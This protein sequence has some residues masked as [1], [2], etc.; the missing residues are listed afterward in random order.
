MKTKTFT[1]LLAM[2][3]LLSAATA[4]NIHYGENFELNSTLN[5]NQSHEYY[6]SDF[7]DLNTGFLSNPQNDNHTLLEINPY[8]NTPISFGTDQYMPQDHDIGGRLG[9]YPMDFHVN[10]YGAATISIPLE[11]PEWI[12]G[13]TPHLSLEYN[14]QAGNGILGLGWSLGGMSKIS[15]V[16]YTYE[17][18]DECHSVQF[19]NEDQLSLDGIILKKGTFNGTTC[20]YPEIYDYS[21]VR[22][23]TGGFKVLRR[24]GTI[25]TYTAKYYLQ[26]AITKPIE[27]HLSNV[28][29]PYGNYIEY[30]YENDRAD[31]AFYP[32]K[33]KYTGRTGHTPA[34]EIRLVYDANDAR[35][36][37]PQKWFSQ[38]S[39]MSCNAGFSRVTRKLSNIECWF[40]EKRIIRYNLTYTT[41]DWNIR[42]LAY[43]EKQFHDY[44]GGTRSYNQVIPLKFVWSKTC[45]NLQYEQAGSMINLNTS[46]N[47]D[48]EWHQQTAFAARFKQDNL[49]NNQ[50]YEHDIVHLMRK[51]TGPKFYHLN[52]FRSNNEIGENGQSYNFNL[53]DCNTINNN[54]FNDG[55]SIN[56][57]MSADTDGDGLDEIVC[58]YSHSNT[59]SISLL[60]P[61]E[62]N[63]FQETVV[64]PSLPSGNFNMSSFQIGDFNGD[65]LSDLFCIY[66]NSIYVRISTVNG[67]FSQPASKELS[68]NDEI[69]I[70]VADFNGDQK[71]QILVLFKNGNNREAKLFQMT[72]QNN[73]YSIPAPRA[74]P[75]EISEKYYLNSF[76]RLCCG[77]FNGDGK[78]DVL[79]ICTGEWRFY[80][81]QGNGMFAPV[82]LLTDNVIVTDNFAT[83]SDTSSMAFAV[84]SDFDHDGCD[85]VSITLQQDFDRLTGYQ[86]YS[87]FRGAFRRDFLIRPQ[88]QGVIVRRIRNLRTW[89]ENGIIQEEDRCI[90]SVV[91]NQETFTSKKVFLPVLGNHKGI[92]PNEILYCRVVNAQSR[93]NIGAFLHN[94]GNFYPDSLTRSVNRI[95]TSLGATIDIRYRPVSY[96]YYLETVSDKSGRSLSEVLPFY[97]FMNVVEEIKKENE[98]DGS[99]MMEGKKYRSSRYYYMRPQI[100]T[101]G[102]GF[103]GFECIWSKTQGQVPAQ[104]IVSVKEYSLDQTYHV[105]VPQKFTLRPPGSTNNYYQR[106]IYT[107]SFSDPD[108]FA[109]SLGQIPN[110]VFAPYLSVATTTR[111]DG[112]PLKY[113]KTVTVRDTYGNVSSFERWYRDN[114]TT[115]YPYY[116]KTETYYD[117]TVTSSRWILGIP[118]SGTTTQRLTDIPPNQV[119]HHTSYQ[120]D[121]THGRHLNKITEPNSDKQ[122]TETYG[123]DGFGNLTSVTEDIGDGH[124]RTDTYVYS[125]DSRFMT[126]HTNAKGHTTQYYYH[127]ATGLLDSVT[128]PN[129][130]TTKY[131]YDYLCNL[132]KTEL[133]SGILEEQVMRWVGHPL[134]NTYHPDTP[135]FGAPIYFVWS[136]RS[137]ER[138]RYTFYDQ[139]RRM[140]REVDSTMDGKKIYVDYRYHD[141]TGL[142]DSVSAPYYPEEHETA[143]F[144]T[145]QYDYLG[146][147][148]W[149][150]RPDGAFTS[151]SYAGQQE[152][153]QGFDGQRRTLTYNPAGLV[154]KVSDHGISN[155]SPVE[156]DYVRYGDGKVKTS[157]VGNESATTITYIYDVNGNP[158]TV[159]DPSLGQLTYDYNG[160]GELVYS[161][162]PRDTVTYTYDALGRMVTRN[163]LDGYSHWQ[164]DA[165]FKGALSQTHYNPVSGP[166]VSEYFTYDR[167]GNPTRHRQQVGANEEWTFVYGYDAYGQR[168]AVTYPSGKKFRWHYDRNGYMDRVTDAASNTMVWQATATDRWGNT[169]EFTEGNIGVAY[170]YDPVSGLL[171]GISARKNGQTLFGQACSWTTVGN[172][173]WR[174]DTTLNLRETFDH[175]RFNRLETAYTKNLVGTTTYSSNSFGFDN[176]G[177][178]TQKDGV[179]SY[180][181]DDAGPYVLTELSPLAGTESLYEDQ[182]ATYTPFDKL[183]SVIQDV[184]T[185]SVNYGI[186]RQRVTQSFTD[187]R[188]TKTKRYFTSL[189][190]TVTENG[191]TK[192]LHYLTSA[193]G[194][195]AIFV[196]TSSGGGTMYYTLKDHQGSLAAVVYGNTM[197]RLSYDAWGNLR[198]PNTWANYTVDDTFDKPMFDRGFTG[199]EHLTDFGLINMNGR[200]YDPIL[201][202][203]LSPDVVIQDEQN[204]QAYNR[205]SYCFNNP[206]RYTDPSGYVVTI[207]PEFE[208]YYMPQY[209]DDFETYKTEL[210]KMDAQNV[211]FNTELSEGKSVTTLTWT[212]GEDSYQMT[213]VDHGLKDYEQM[214]ENSCV[215]SALAA[216]EARFVNGNKI[217]SEAYI[218]DNAKATCKQGMTVDAGLGVLLPKTN[219]YRRVP[220]Y[221]DFLEDESH[222]L[223]YYEQ[224]SFDEMSRNNGVFFRFFNSQM[225]HVMNA[226]QAISFI[227]NGRKEAHEIRLW[228]SDFNDGKIGGYKSMTEYDLKIFYGKF[229]TLFINKP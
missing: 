170:G 61:N 125:T 128:D 49:L 69:R 46:Y 182:I 190:E 10:E 22:P 21:A 137:G 197:E 43:V 30:E 12:N 65:G 112:S 116:E 149:I 16:P 220:V 165:G 124:P 87:T 44:P 203:M 216:Q 27:W 47:S 105:L 18:N 107:Y 96:Q 194:L 188:I 215:A 209:L 153:M 100:H 106:T 95:V 189:Y 75:D 50:K 218:M 192:K 108:D 127:D 101:R 78:K 219:V 28:E 25:A 223:N 162:T 31:G 138:A 67:A 148:T 73:T 5:A 84:V 155:S 24:D 118:N 145:Y 225:S 89:S 140:L 126:S 9:F 185:L 186:D 221:T 121:M 98:D 135:D 187:G 167:L 39:D 93:N 183:R 178:I 154:V 175:D 103:L 158:S 171:T 151:H 37:C 17:Y 26:Q 56:A 207:P 217:I 53:Y 139:H 97:G 40:G 42:A 35:P 157:V 132:I 54:H 129:G 86:S 81:S 8:Y 88:K 174:T 79:L 90:D 163:G 173:E 91:T 150:T 161:A 193:T 114:T 208:K 70:V 226:S 20:Y 213:I 34:Y 117:N 205:Y 63:I 195:F 169:T 71:D 60:T 66:D 120:N 177:N 119:V 13:M 36:D 113:E 92:S 45:H 134:Q 48:Q 83:T 74:V 19:S 222:G 152:T 201:G 55:R 160:F 85:D 191:V 38:P 229:G 130:L 77:D 15:R 3:V 168:N 210:E 179:G 123:Y 41:L 29:D 143:R 109:S 104:D 172:L 51:E 72:E 94:T 184:D 115:T 111:N 164:Y 122:L 212:L 2:T 4:Q 206:L 131:H 142:L 59:L 196:S 146:R 52:V 1:V 198:D 80:F 224:R 6:A 200:L 7:I 62:N 68:L 76:K 180:T 99:G 199:H 202:R 58:V 176:N 144:T 227:L 204:S 141:V 64:V 110:G 181:Y 228:D 214:C 14:S 147:N 156:I 166:A 33:I 11:F 136:K 159:A 23:I 133:P 32:T 211:A 82:Q 57:F 102:R